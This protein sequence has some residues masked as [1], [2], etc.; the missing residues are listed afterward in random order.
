MGHGA[1]DHRRFLPAAASFRPFAGSDL[2]ARIGGQP[3][4]DRLVDTLY[5]RFVADPQ[6]RP[7]FDRDLTVERA[8]QKRFFGEWLGGPPAYSDFAWAGLAHRHAEL[9]IDRV[10][11]RRPG[12]GATALH[13]AARAGFLRTIAPPL[14]EGADP[15][16]RDQEGATPL[17]WLARAAKSV[18]RAAVRA[19]LARRG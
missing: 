3:A 2:F 13:H 1:L 14:A 16:A 4:V 5:D 15:E 18:D 10:D 12:S 8:R 6:L 19:L 9:P 17:D 7:L 11:D